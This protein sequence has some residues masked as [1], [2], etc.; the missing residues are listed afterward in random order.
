[1]ELFTGHVDFKAD[2]AAGL[3]R[4]LLFVPTAG[5][6]Y[7]TRRNDD[8]GP[9][10]RSNVSALSPWIRHRLV[11]EA[12]VCRAVLDTHSAAAAEKF[13]QEVFWRTY[14]K[15]WLELRP[16]VWRAYCSERDQA[17]GLV[18]QDA[19]LATDLAAARS[20]RTG[21]DCFDAWALELL[22]TGYL[23]NHARMWFASIWIFTLRLPWTLGADW[24]LAHLMDGDPAS[25]TLSWR[26][27]AGLQTVG[28]HYV[29][30]ADTI[31]RHTG[32]RFVPKGLA[33][34]PE[35]L[36]GG[37]WPQASRLAPAG[38]PD[39]SKPAFVLITPE[40]CQLG[41]L[42]AADLPV[43]GLGYL[44]PGA[45]RSPTELGGPARDFE[46]GAVADGWAC[47]CRQR[48]VSSSLPDAPVLA[49]PD[50]LVAAAREA[51]ASQ[52]VTAQ[53]PVGPLADSFA[54]TRPVLAAQGLDFVELRRDWDSAAW[55]RATRGFFAFREAIPELL[56]RAGLSGRVD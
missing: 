52:I 43:A 23:H 9:Q 47:L 54:A 13:I 38:R 33:A 46:A 26:W 49:E 56:A 31:M 44:V 42:I 36:R 16:D 53:I 1:M 3:A 29:A 5:R 32:G 41:T 48:T 15:G 8:L 55:P 50:A 22:E 19:A 18:A 11:S 12:E 21:I 17:L 20:G 4:L 30:R 10:D 14:W 24:F 34:N 37:D 28:K 7:Q 51:G 6:S 2:R 40:D 35:P 45:L 39:P 27:V 25:N